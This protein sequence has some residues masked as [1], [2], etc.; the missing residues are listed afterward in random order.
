MP[1]SVPDHS[2]ADDPRLLAQ[3]EPAIASGVR[4]LRFDSELEDRYEADTHHQR[5]QFLTSIGIIGGRVYNCTM[6]NTRGAIAHGWHR[7]IQP[8][9]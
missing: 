9:V 1:F 7:L 6:P 8:A 4:S 2:T 3:V 5:L